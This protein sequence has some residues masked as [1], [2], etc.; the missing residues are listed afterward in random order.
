[1]LQ[2]ISDKEQKTISISFTECVRGNLIA[3]ILTPFLLSIYSFE[4]V[5]FVSHN[6]LINH[7]FLYAILAFSF[8]KGSIK[9]LSLDCFNLPIFT[10]L[11]VFFTLILG[12]ILDQYV[13]SFYLS[14]ARVPIFFLLLIGCIPITFYI[15]LFYSD[16]HAGLWKASMCKICLILSL[17]FAGIINFKELFLLGYAILLL[18]V[19]WLVFGF[20]AHF[21]L[22]RVGS[23]LSI[24]F[25]NG[26]T[27]AW[28][29]STTLPLYLS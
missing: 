10:G 3:L 18:C 19:F 4:W 28:T 15:Q 17:L 24:A 21:L 1:M 27:L 25:A 5:S 20:L 9:S 26:V 13:S 8:T 12:Y 29:F 14:G 11:V 6:Y 2:N 7:L 16:S 23:F 22:R